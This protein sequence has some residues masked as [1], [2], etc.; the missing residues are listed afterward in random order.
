MLTFPSLSFTDSEP[1]RETPF[2]TMLRWSRINSPAFQ[3]GQEDWLCRTDL[4]DLGPQWASRLLCCRYAKLLF[5]A[6]PA[7]HIALSLAC[8]LRV[9][10]VP[11]DF[12]LFGQGLAAAATWGD[13]LEFPAPGDHSRPRQ[14]P[15]WFSEAT[16]VPPCG[17]CSSHCV[18]RVRP[19]SGCQAL[20]P[21]RTCLERWGLQERTLLI[22]AQ[23]QTNYFRNLRSLCWRKI[24][25]PVREQCG[26]G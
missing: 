12:C 6:D 4:E 9:S 14:V 13:L 24:E 5:K 21:H 7:H 16:G 11:C 26:A 20:N 23:A 18:L 8:C 17:L 1:W 10:K 25:R 15:A 22:W 2:I 19:A 3:R